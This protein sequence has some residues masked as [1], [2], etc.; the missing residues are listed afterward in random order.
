MV[1]D[2]Q[3]LTW[4][5]R[6]RELDVRWNLRIQDTPL[7]Q[8]HS[9]SVT[10]VKLKNLLQV[11]LYSDY[12]PD[13]G[14]LPPLTPCP[15]PGLAPETHQRLP[16]SGVAWGTHCPRYSPLSCFPACSCRLLAKRHA[17]DHFLGLPGKPC[18]WYWPPRFLTLVMAMK[19]PLWIARAC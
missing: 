19:G 8:G 6:V 5:S 16:S 9:G 2:L 18:S 3:A 11:V 17:S 15:P 12:N 7:D 14:V 1:M 13:S 4:L 10:W